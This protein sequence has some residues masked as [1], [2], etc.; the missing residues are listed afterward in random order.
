MALKNS[1]ESNGGSSATPDLQDPDELT[2]SVGDLSKGQE[3][4]ETEPAQEASAFSKIPSDRPHTEPTDPATTTRIQF[5]HPNG[6]II[7]RFNVNDPVQRIYEWLKAEPLEGKEG[8]EF[9]LK[10]MPAGKDLIEVLDQ[11]IEEAGLKQATV[12]VEFIE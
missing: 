1:M 6:R 2:K 4:E 11:G 9:E 5:R 7:R 12:M 8:V 10:T 3:A